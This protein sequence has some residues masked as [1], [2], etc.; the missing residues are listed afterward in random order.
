[1]G[2]GSMRIA[3]AVDGL[4][5][6]YGSHTAVDNLSFELPTG[7][8]RGF[9]GPN[10]ACE[11]TS[12]AMLLGL[13]SL[14]SGSATVLGRSLDEP[15]SYDALERGVSRVAPN[16]PG[17]T[18]ARRSP[19]C[20]ATST[21]WPTRC[22]RS[23]TTGASPSSR[24]ST[25]AA[26]SGDVTELWPPPASW[27]GAIPAGDGPGGCGAHRRRGGGSSTGGAL[28]GR[29]ESVRLLTTPRRKEPEVAGPFAGDRTA[30]AKR[31][32]APSATNP[33]A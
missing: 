20:A 15:A 33:A 17:P 31:C 30:S 16:S 23:T 24:V 29:A 7:V 12:I 9:I 3:V 28:A 19:T 10:G 6:R 2:H 27:L 13:V 5:K 18:S 32:L 11:T 26:R 4:T 25:R 14:A 21:P 22:H 1:M 8:G